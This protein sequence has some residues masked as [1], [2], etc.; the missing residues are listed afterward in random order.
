MRSRN[1][2]N[3]ANPGCNMRLNFPMRS[4]IHA[5]CCGTNLIIVFAGS[6]GLWKNEGVTL[7]PEGLKPR[8]RIEGEFEGAWEG[9]VL[10]KVRRA[11]MAAGLVVRAVRREAWRMPFVLVSASLRAEEAILG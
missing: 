3:T 4:T 2:I 1:G 7:E 6:D 8:P 9:G 5:V 10:L 11:A